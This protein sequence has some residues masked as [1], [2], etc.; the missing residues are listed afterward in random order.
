VICA[1]HFD[2]KS[3]KRILDL[4]CEYFEVAMDNRSKNPF[5]DLI[6][7]L[8][9]ILLFF[10]V[11]PNLLLC[12]NIKPN[13]Y[14]SIVAMCFRVATINNITGLGSVFIRETFMTRFLM[15]IY[16]ISL[17]KSFRVFFQNKEDKAFF[18]SSSLVRKEVASLIPGSGVDLCKFKKMPLRK[19]SGVDFFF[20]GR[21]ILDKGIKQYIEAA[22]IVRHSH[23][24]SR[25]FVL[26]FIDESNENAIS[27]KLIDE[28]V[29]RGD[30]IY[31]GGESED[32]RPYI[33]IADCIVLPSFYREGVPRILLEASAMGRIII[34]T[35]HIGCR[36]AVD[37][38]K[39]GYLCEPLNVLDLADKMQI[40]INQTHKNRQRMG[41]AGRLKMKKEFD[42]QIVLDAY[43]Y[44]ID[45]VS[46]K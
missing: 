45:L 16:K 24:N 42:E 22:S 41:N 15:F 30:I 5:K 36:D 9:I 11:R 31:M 17:S 38:Q 44:Q 18:L 39:T 20:I 29:I 8:K 3:V 4:G 33:D 35:N 27:S 28:S 23:P 7:I 25:F 37:D 2:K 1:S 26:G 32:V 19:K 46:K 21:L 6:L 14:G 34:T 10:R 43:S 12:F 40:V 13:I